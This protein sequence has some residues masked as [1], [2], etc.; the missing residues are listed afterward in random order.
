MELSLSI[1]AEEFSCLSCI[2]IDRVADFVTLEELRPSPES[3]LAVMCM[4]V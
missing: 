4:Y 1:S 2:S 3:E